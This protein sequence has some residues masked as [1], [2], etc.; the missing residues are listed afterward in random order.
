[1]LSWGAQVTWIVT[2]RMKTLLVRETVATYP[3][4]VAD[5]ACTHCHSLH[6]SE[7]RL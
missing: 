3:Y 7:Q 5:G 4:T 2:L 6:G 1:M